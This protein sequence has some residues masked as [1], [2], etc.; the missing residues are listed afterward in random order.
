M[1]RAVHLMATT[2]QV[3]IIAGLLIS[4]IVAIV[5]FVSKMIKSK[6]GRGG[7]Y[8]WRL[9]NEFCADRKC[10]RCGFSYMLVSADQ[11]ARICERCGL[12]Q[13]LQEFVKDARERRKQGI[14]KGSLI[15]CV[16][17]ATWLPFAIVWNASTL[18][19]YASANLRTFSGSL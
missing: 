15:F 18:D 10:P 6:G 4:G 2:V 14:L 17:V 11:S 3:V 19:S 16:W 12:R 5:A 1:S 7:G 8:L 13:T 9:M